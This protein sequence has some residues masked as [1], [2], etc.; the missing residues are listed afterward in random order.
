MTRFSLGWWFLLAYGAWTSISCKST[1]DSKQ[2]F[3]FKPGREDYDPKQLQYFKSDPS[4]HEASKWFEDVPLATSGIPMIMFRVFPDFAPDIWGPDMTDLSHLG[5]PRKPEAFGP[6]SPLPLGMGYHRS[7]KKILPIDITSMQVVGLSCAACHTGRV[8]LQDGTV[9]YLLGGS[10]QQFDP[11]KFGDA[12][13]Q[14]VSRPNFTGATFRAIIDKKSKLQPWIFNDLRMMPQQALELNIFLSKKDENGNFASDAIVQSVKEN[15]IK[16][17]GVIDDVLGKLYTKNHPS[18][19][20]GTPGQADALGKIAVIAGGTPLTAASVDLPAV[21]RQD[22]REYAQFD[23][24]IRDPLFRNIAAEFGVGGVAEEVN[25]VNAAVTADLVMTLPAPGYP[26]TIDKERAQKGADLFQRYC[27]ACHGSTESGA[28]AKTVRIPFGVDPAASTLR[29]LQ[30][31]RQAL[32]KVATALKTSCMTGLM[33]DS[34]TPW[35]PNSEKSV[36]MQR[37]EV[38]PAEILYDQTNNPGIVGQ[39][40]AGIWAT[41][42][43]LHNGSIPTLRALLWPSKRPEAFFRGNLGYDER[44]LGY[45]YD[46]IESDN[47]VGAIYDTRLMGNSNQGH[48]NAAML[49]RDWE[50]DPEGTQDLLEYLKTL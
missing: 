28:P 2:Q 20:G 4:M 9:R 48:A 24:S 6:N 35:I 14:T 29:A 37:C 8:R 16:R 22:T 34:R 13:F 12:V 23:G 25:V 5:L 11:N 26:F 36:E 49:G 31:D 1:G 7:S 38:D 15:V 18:L 27:A 39:P 45:I 32:A 43:Y 17:Q 50:K 19:Y 44:D 47:K 41:A 42:P 30:L 3:Y 46:V 33:K 40:L 21:W 10:S